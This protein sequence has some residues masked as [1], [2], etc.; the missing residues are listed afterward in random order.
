MSRYA[1][2]DIHGCA[3]TLSYALDAIGFNHKDELFLLGDYIDRGA[4]SI[5]V[6]KKIWQLEADGY[7]VISLR[8]NHEQM[9]LNYL[10]GKRR[11]YEWAPKRVDQEAVQAWMNDLPYYHETPGYLLVHAGL[12][13]Q[14]PNPLADRKEMLWIRNW[15]GDLD[16]EW[17]GDRIIVHGHT[18]AAVEDIQR[19]IFYMSNTQRV[20]ID[21][22][23]AWD[24][25]G[26]QH[27]TVLDLD[28]QTGQFF[29]RR[30]EGKSGLFSW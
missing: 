18:P 7:Q 26:L 13:F 22:G 3:A 28:T 14:Y 21:S 23:C 6:L 16:K 10:A 20:C 11:R 30:R 8:G 27:L 25:P 4:D 1:I 2:S 15:Y 24:K 17:L 9:L 5:G 12:N 29:K 19:S